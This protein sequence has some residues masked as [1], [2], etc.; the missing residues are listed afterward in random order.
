MFRA[1]GNEVVYLKRLSIGSLKLDENLPLGGFRELT[2][3][4]IE[5][6]LVFSD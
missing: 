4:E 2:E 5:N 3:T 6:L 1:V